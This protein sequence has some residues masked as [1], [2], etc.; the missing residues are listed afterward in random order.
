MPPRHGDGSEPGHLHLVTPGTRLDV[1]TLLRSIRRCPRPG[2]PE[3]LS[4]AEAARRSR[5]H[6]EPPVSPRHWRRVEDGEARPQAGVLLRMAL[7]VGATTRQIRRLFHLA[8]YGQ[9]YDTLAGTA[10]GRPC[11][12]EAGILADPR[13]PDEGR[14][15][16][17]GHLHDVVNALH[18]RA[19][20]GGGGG[21]EEP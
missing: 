17:L 20:R 10:A 7:A 1:G 8:G 21:R 11:P 6:G 16:L 19:R 5:M 15:V 3:G 14:R 18:V 4:V 13:L 2:R 9:L 12:A